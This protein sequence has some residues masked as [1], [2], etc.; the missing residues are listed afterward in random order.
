MASHP[1]AIVHAELY[2]PTRRIEDGTV[3]FAEGRVLALGPA[4]EVPV[5]RRAERID[6]DAVATAR[7]HRPG[8][9]QRGRGDEQQQHGQE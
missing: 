7:P 5:P 4:R 8:D 2:T 6:A 9:P 3:V 1:V